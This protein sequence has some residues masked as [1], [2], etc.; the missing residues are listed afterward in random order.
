MNGDQYSSRREAEHVTL[1]FDMHGPERSFLL[2]EEPNVPVSVS[3]IVIEVCCAQLS[4]LDSQLEL[5]SRIL[6][7][8]LNRGEDKSWSLPTCTLKHATRLSR[9]EAAIGR[10]CPGSGRQ[11]IRT[12]RLSS[13]TRQ[14]RIQKSSLNPQGKDAC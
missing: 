9:S 10:G 7:W 3:G 8:F 11:S 4:V 14:P 12:V 5:N 6:Y 13:S 1:S 2:R